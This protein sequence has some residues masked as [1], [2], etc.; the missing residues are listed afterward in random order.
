LF[1]NIRDIRKVR[2]RQL[3]NPEF[4]HKQDEIQKRL[5]RSTLAIKEGGGVRE[6]QKTINLGG[7]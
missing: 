4:G 6:T 3:Q 7:R 5:A 2:K 1:T